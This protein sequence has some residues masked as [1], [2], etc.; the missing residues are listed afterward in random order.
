MAT[1]FHN[2]DKCC[3]GA[4]LKLGC[5]CVYADSAKRR[6][7]SPSRIT[8]RYQL[9]NP[10]LHTSLL[11]VWPFPLPH[12]S[13]SLLPFEFFLIPSAFP[14]LL[15]PSSLPPVSSPLQDASFAL[16]LQTLV[17]V[18][19]ILL[20]ASSPLPAD[21]RVVWS[22][23]IFCCGSSVVKTLSMSEEFVF[24]SLPVLLTFGHE[25]PPLVFCAAQP[26]Q[27]SFPCG[28]GENT[29]LPQL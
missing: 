5:V 18:S 8:R 13:A 23:S 28:M 9:F 21:S 2:I 25:L 19:A 15:L 4:T 17:F 1:G 16:P 26:L 12:G 10:H 6:G 24:Y 20:V 14:S 29:E 11:P 7:P 27:S 3:S 22:N